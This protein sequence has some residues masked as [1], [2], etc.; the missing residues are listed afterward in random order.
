MFI[1]FKQPP[2]LPDCRAACSPVCSLCAF[3]C[4]PVP[5]FV[6]QCPPDCQFPFPQAKTGT[7]VAVQLPRTAWCALFGVEVASFYAALQA[8]GLTTVPSWHVIDSP[9][10]SELGSSR[11]DLRQPLE[12][13]SNRTC[14]SP[15]LKG[16]FGAWNL[17]GAQCVDQVRQ[18]LCG[19]PTL[20]E[21]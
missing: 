3:T 6:S 17:I 19:P 14:D 7:G 4:L 2:L 12:G 11:G 13:K 8:K 18:G 16:S 5:S 15:P 9:Q 20:Q 21:S 10:C 1:P